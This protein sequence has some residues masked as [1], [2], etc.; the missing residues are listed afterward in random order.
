M[1]IRNMNFDTEHDVVVY[2]RI[3]KTGSSSLSRML[4]E[5][6]GEDRTGRLSDRQVDAL[7]FGAAR[8]HDQLRR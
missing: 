7:D 6:F 8:L 5:M 4:S 3:P 2:L 1:L